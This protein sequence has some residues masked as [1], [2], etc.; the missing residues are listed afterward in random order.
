MRQVVDELVLAGFVVQSNLDSKVMSSLPSDTA[1]QLS[2]LSG[3]LARIEKELKDPD[4]TLSKLEGRIKSLEDRQARDVIE[5][6]GKTFQDL[7]AVSAWV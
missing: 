4:G 3:R 5:R 7:G 6:G 2:G 1:N